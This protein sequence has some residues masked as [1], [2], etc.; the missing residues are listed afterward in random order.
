[1]MES[2]DKGKP[3]AV[4]RHAILRKLEVD[5]LTR[6]R[7]YLRFAILSNGL[8]LLF[9]SPCNTNGSEGLEALFPLFLICDFSS[10]Q[11]TP[12]GG[13]CVIRTAE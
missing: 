13:R 11:E 10:W 12:V 8:T 2:A 3:D 1:M 4:V 6:L 9:Q 5:L 7:T